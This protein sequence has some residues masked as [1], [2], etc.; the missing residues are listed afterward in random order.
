MKGLVLEPKVLDE[1]VIVQVTTNELVD[2]HLQIKVPTGFQAIVFIDEK[3]PFR[4]EPTNG[5]FI[6]KRDKHY[7][8]KQCK[9]AFIR[10]KLLPDMAWG[11]GPVYV[12]NERLEEAYRVGANGKYSIE[13]KEIAKLFNGFDESK[14][15]TVDD[16][17]SRTI[18]IVKNVGTSVLGKY[19]ANT[20][21][22]LFEISAHTDEIRKE[23]FASLEKETAFLEIGVRIKD[24]TIAGIHVPEEDVLLIK[25][26]I[27]K[28]DEKIEKDNIVIEDINNKVEKLKE[29][30][31]DFIEESRKEVA[32]TEDDS[33]LNI[34]DKLLKIQST[35]E[36]I[37]E[38]KA[39]E[40]NVN[41]IDVDKQREELEKVVSAA[42]VES[43]G[44]LQS[45][46][47]D[48]VASKV[49]EQS[50]MWRDSLLAGIDEKLQAMKPVET[51]PEVVTVFSVESILRNARGDNELILAAGGIHTAMEDALMTEHGLEQRN[52]K[53]V[54]PYQEYI[55]LANSVKLNNKYMLKRK[56]ADGYEMIPPNIVTRH[57]DG[58]PDLVEMLPIV[59]F[60][61]TGL[62]P[63]EAKHAEEIGVVINKLRH[64]SPDNKE[65]IE[66]FFVRKRI[67]K[68]EYLINALEFLKEKKLYI[69]K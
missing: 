62:S 67:D 58:S 34:N 5:E 11:C 54:I 41:V 45:I 25:N 36:S 31:T 65:F 38:Y 16:V 27:N 12:N 33:I 15:F 4:V 59:R 30:V 39:T 8:K 26:R 64:P 3:N 51:K 52:K 57:A 9:V 24:L 17:R 63:E 37:E 56:T 66:R 13:I 48:A 43:F 2:K 18:S 20:E 68:K 40:N 7:L 46:I 22:S 47:E 50:K 21:I 44:S 61:K 29:L 60:L 35:I 69:V 42:I 14:N 49:E 10:K 19:F 55:E 23:M 32:V 28:A 6:Y 53:F 1:N